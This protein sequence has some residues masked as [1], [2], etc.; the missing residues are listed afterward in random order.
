MSAARKV[1]LRT[2]L[3]RNM[4]E[5]FSQ[6][7]IEQWINAVGTV[8]GKQD[9][10]ECAGDIAEYLSAVKGFQTGEELVL[11]E[12]ADIEEARANGQLQISDVSIKTIWRYMTSRDTSKPDNISTSESTGLSTGAENA[13]IKIANATTSKA[14]EMKENYAKVKSV[15][16]F[17]NEYAKSK[18]NEW[19]GTGLY[20]ALMSV[21]KNASM[22]KESMLEHAQ[23]KLT[24][25]EK[26]KTECAVFQS[27]LSEAI[28]QQANLEACTTQLH[29]QLLL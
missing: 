16:Q 3:A 25:M 6:V 4:D 17:I 1:E 20:E 15:R 12:Q 27:A 23:D 22:T 7:E 26:D 11:A 8:M 29:R 28:Q 14:P 10:V 19:E 5:Q 24:D 18:K 13:L 9:I 21:R 2:H